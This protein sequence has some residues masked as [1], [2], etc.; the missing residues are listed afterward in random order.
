MINKKLIE[1]TTGKVI[2]AYNLMTYSAMPTTGNGK[3]AIVNG[4][5]QIYS[6]DLF[7]IIDDD[8][9][10][11][12]VEPSSLKAICWNCNKEIT[13]IKRLR[14]TGNQHCHHCNVPINRELL[15]V[16]SDLSKCITLFDSLSNQERSIIMDSYDHNGIKQTL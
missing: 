2:T 9:K 7:V 1:T 3:S 11:H 15:Q 10:K 16:E 14:K 4:I 12:I 5:L 8:L 6:D 13:T